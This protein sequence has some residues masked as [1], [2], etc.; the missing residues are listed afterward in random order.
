VTGPK[1]TVTFTSARGTKQRTLTVE[2]KLERTWLGNVGG[3]DTI[4]LPDLT[5]IPL[6]C[7]TYFEDPDDPDDHH[8]DPP[9][10]D[11]SA[12]VT[13][14]GKDGTRRHV[15]YDTEVWRIR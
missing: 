13:I 1:V 14:E 6:A 11:R 5:V 3:G 4:V 2:A 10:G 8:C 7:G 9:A 15:P 12:K